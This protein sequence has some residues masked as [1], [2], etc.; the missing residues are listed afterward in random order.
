M[1]FKEAVETCVKHKYATFSGRASRSEFWWFMLFLT[2]GYLV[3][4]GIAIAGIDFQ[5]GEPG[6]LTFIF[7]G[8]LAIFLIAMFIPV[9]ATTIR[10]FHDRN[11]SGWWYLGFIALS[12]IP[13]VGIVASIAQIVIF[14]LKGTEG[15]NRFG[16]DPLSGPMDAD[17]FS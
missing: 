5:N 10:R 15:E 6:T 4:G 9:L 7:G 1:K 11:M 13:F 2:I 8:L 3:L 16:A 17:V 14:C 12:M